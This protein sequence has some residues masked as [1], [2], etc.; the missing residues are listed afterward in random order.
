MRLGKKICS[1]NST[2]ILKNSLSIKK[3][4]DLFLQVENN[5]LN[6]FIFIFFKLDSTHVFKALLERSPMLNVFRAF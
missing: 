1:V 4:E 2:L 6:D 3:L 5:L